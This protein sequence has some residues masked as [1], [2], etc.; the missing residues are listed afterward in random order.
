MSGIFILIALVLAVVLAFG[1]WA[2]AKRS[3]RGPG[4]VKP[5]AQPTPE[6]KKRQEPRS[7]L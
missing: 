3:D 6:E 2:Y 5:G 7:G 4:K 1:T